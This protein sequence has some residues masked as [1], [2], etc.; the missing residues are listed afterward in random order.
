MRRM[1]VDSIR[2]EMRRS[3]G[4]VGKTVVAMVDVVADADFLS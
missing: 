2:L 1:L 3:L 4:T